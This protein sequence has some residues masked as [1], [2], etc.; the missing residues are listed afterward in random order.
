MFFLKCWSCVGSNSMFFPSIAN[1]EQKLLKEMY[2]YFD[3]LYIYIER[4][5]EIFYLYRPVYKK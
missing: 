5:R 4:E 3:I 1:H 2:V